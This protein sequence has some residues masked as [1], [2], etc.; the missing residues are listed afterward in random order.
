MTIFQRKTS[1]LPKPCTMKSQTSF[2]LIGLVV[3]FCLLPVTM[4][5]QSKN[6]LGQGSLLNSF[7]CSV[8]D[9]AD[10]SHPT[11]P[12][13]MDFFTDSN[14]V[15]QP[16]FLLYLKSLY[17]GEVARRW[18]STEVV[19]AIAS[20]QDSMSKTEPN[21]FLTAPTAETVTLVVVAWLDGQWCYQCVDPTGVTAF[22]KGLRI[23]FIRSE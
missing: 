19:S 20:L 18:E 8:F 17:E 21:L 7:T 2:A 23:Y 3:N 1:P 15:E 14:V 12:A 4:T 22:D 16:V 6:I 10:D 11:R 13:N 5:A 9:K